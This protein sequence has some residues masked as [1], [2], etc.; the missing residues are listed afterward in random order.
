MKDEEMS[1]EYSDHNVLLQRP[2][3]SA[4]PEKE[5]DLE[6]QSSPRTPNKGSADLLKR[7]DR[8]LSGRK[9]P[10]VKRSN[11]EHS[12]PYSPLSRRVDASGGFSNDAEEDEVLGDSAPPEWALLLVG[13]LL[14][15]ATGL[16][17]AVFNRGVG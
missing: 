10:T 4:S 6:A 17:V 9:S 12:S 2:V 7:L 8:N 5:G 1:G 16:C 14:G 3:S 11:R 15:L 13:C